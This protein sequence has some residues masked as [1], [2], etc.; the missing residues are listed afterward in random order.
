M[1]RYCMYLTYNTI[2]CLPKHSD[3]GIA[4]KSL[5]IGTVHNK[6]FS[7]GYFVGNDNSKHF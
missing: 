6:C 7:F 1:N 2:L 4:A 5:R 3:V